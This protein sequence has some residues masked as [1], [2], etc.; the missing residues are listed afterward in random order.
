MPWQRRE[1]KSGGEVEHEEGGEGCSGARQL[2][3]VKV[4]FAVVMMKSIIFRLRIEKLT[5]VHLRAFCLHAR[6]HTPAVN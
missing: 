1:G 5:H 2:D 4:L 3:T 6:I